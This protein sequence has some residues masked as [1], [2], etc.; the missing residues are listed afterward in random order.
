MPSKEQAASVGPTFPPSTLILEDWQVPPETGMLDGKPVRIEWALSTTHHHLSLGKSAWVQIKT[1]PLETVGPTVA[2]I[3]LPDGRTFD[4]PHQC[5]FYEDGSEIYTTCPIC[6]KQSRAVEFYI[7]NPKLGI[8]D[9]R[10]RRRRAPARKSLGVIKAV[11]GLDGVRRTKLTINHDVSALDYAKA[12]TAMHGDGTRT[13]YPHSRGLLTAF[14]RDYLAA[15]GTPGES[16]DAYSSAL[17]HVFEHM[18]D[19]RPDYIASKHRRR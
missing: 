6:L 2:T 15:C 9:N 3:E 4:V 12:L 8:Y 16:L 17:E 7:V 19:L 1:E 5:L 13:P 11:R 14:M 10:G 18:P